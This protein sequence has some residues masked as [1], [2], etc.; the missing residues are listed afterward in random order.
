M[1][2]SILSAGRQVTM[3][4]V[5]YIII[6][7]VLIVT[8]CI[9]DYVSRTWKSGICTYTSN[10]AKRGASPQDISMLVS[11]LSVHPSIR[12]G[13]S[14]YIYSLV[15]WNGVLLEI[16]IFAL[17]AR[18]YRLFMKPEG[19]L[20]CLLSPPLGPIIPK[21]SDSSP[22]HHT[23]VLDENPWCRVTRDKLI[24]IQLVNNLPSFMNPNYIR[25]SRH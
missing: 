22:H 1:N 7:C 12:H 13:N 4:Y 9:V 23:L 6:I 24:V 10:E 11:K 25:Y 18:N 2:G 14:L 17:L 15:S 5:M 16:I 21:W 20:P 8:Y 3:L 19:S